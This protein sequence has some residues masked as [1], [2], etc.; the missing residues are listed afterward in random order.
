MKL[1]LDTHVHT[2]ASGHAYS[3]L[4]EYIEMAKSQGLDL[5]GI[6][7]HG[8]EMPG[9]PHIY[10][11]GNQIV[12]PE[13]ME[14]IRVLKGVEANIMD[15]EGAID[16]PERYLQY[17]DIVLASLHHQCFSAGTAKENTEAL[18][19]TM[20]NPY[21]DVIAHSGNPTFPIDIPRFVAAAKEHH[22]LIEINNSSFTSISRSGS[23]ENCVAIAA[24]ANRIGAHVIAGS[25]SHIKYTLGKFDKVMDVFE[26]V[27]M[28]EALIMNTSK[29][30]LLDYLRANGKKV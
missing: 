10:H 22:V 4:A 13:V 21:V 15:C 14:G 27:G 17:L 26:R 24:E 7:D 5:I 18:I 2:L 29:D 9:G 11:I 3:T 28:K 16:V 30:K 8:P 25:D 23:T 12:M 1:V 19:N 6:T 20:K